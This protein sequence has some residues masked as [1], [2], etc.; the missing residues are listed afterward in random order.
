M[1]R[2]RLEE[3]DVRDNA[4]SAEALLVPLDAVR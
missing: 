2:T 1:A 3:F 4:A